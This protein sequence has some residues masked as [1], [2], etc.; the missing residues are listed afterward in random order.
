MYM[1]ERLDGLADRPVMDYGFETTRKSKRIITDELVE[2]IRESPRCE[3]D[4]ATLKEMSTFVTKENGEREALDG[5]HD[6]LVMSLAITHFISK[7]QTSSWMV[8]ESGDNEFIKEN[9]NL[10]ESRTV[11]DAGPYS[12]EGAFMDWD[13]L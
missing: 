7:K 8:V 12:S 3:C 4:V 6:D 13:E 11:G 9:F 1:R 10:D 2:I 5:Y